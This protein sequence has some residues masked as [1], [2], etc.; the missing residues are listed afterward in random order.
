MNMCKNKGLE[1]EAI[2][3]WNDKSERFCG[4]Y[5]KKGKTL[6]KEINS[7]ECEGPDEKK[8]GMAAKK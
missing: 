4:M 7:N 2:T 6:D 1:N 5:K 8:Y 3:Q